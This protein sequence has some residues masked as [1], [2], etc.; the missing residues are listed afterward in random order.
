MI[1]DA[2]IFPPGN[3]AF[4]TAL[5]DHLTRRTEPWAALV[6]TF[7]ISDH[8]LAEL[9]GLVPPNAGPEDADPYPTDPMALSILI[10]GGAW[11]LPPD[12]SPAPRLA[13][14]GSRA[15]GRG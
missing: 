10:G 11:G 15:V 6:D 13:G 7:V 4:D 3:A 14:C 2:A 1:D 9:R 12:A 8:R 5:T